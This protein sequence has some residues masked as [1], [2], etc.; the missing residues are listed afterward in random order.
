MDVAAALS[1]GS[2]IVGVKGGPETTGGLS[3]V[4]TQGALFKFCTPAIE[5]LTFPVSK[6]MKSPV[7]SVKTTDPALRGFE[8][9]VDKGISAI[10]VVDP[11]GAIVHNT[12]TS[13]VKLLF[14]ATDDDDVIMN[15]NMENFLVHLRAK[16]AAT[17]SKTKIPV[18][19][20]QKGDSFGAVIKKLAKTGYHHVWVVNLDRSCAGVVSLTDVF[21]K[22]SVDKK[23]CVIL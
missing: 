4:I 2:H 11:D 7:I 15:E 20:C 3:A 12:S 19:T 9:M 14:S 8:V 16:Q 13:D 23:D 6:V 17:R 18:S 21:R 1:S 10:A 22:F 5:T